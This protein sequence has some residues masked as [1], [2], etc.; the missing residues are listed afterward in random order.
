VTAAPNAAQE[1][2]WDGPEGG[3]WAGHADLLEGSAA[4]YDPALLAAAA[5]D[6]GSRVLDVGCGTGSVTRAA[7]RRAGDGTA[8]GVDLSSAMIAVARARAAGAGLTNATFVRSDAQVHPFPTAAFDVVLSRTGASFFG[9]APA[10]FANLAR[11]TAVGGRLAL[12]S[13]QR[14]ERNEWVTEI[15]GALAGRPL[16]TPPAG[17]PGPFGL[18]E[19]EYA[20]RLLR[21]AGFVDVRIDDV[22]EPMLLGPD[23]RAARDV[24]ADLLSWLYADRDAAGRDR[25]RAALL[26]AMEAHDGPDGVAFGSA[27]WLIRA[28]RRD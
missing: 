26:A 8:L 25:A 20:D 14:P 10:A 18:A 16:P 2:A 21:D 17:A 13:W 27:A 12:V 11:A 9:D 15:A 19:P 1:R 23:P 6:A 7:A 4:R 3:V 5:I 24:M 28:V 22:R